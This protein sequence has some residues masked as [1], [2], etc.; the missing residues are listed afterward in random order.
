MIPHS[1][2][3]ELQI[4]NMNGPD[5]SPDTI[6]EAQDTILESADLKFD[7]TDC[8]CSPT[9]LQELRELLRKHS[10]AFVDKTELGVCPH[11][12]HKIIL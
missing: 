10:K 2:I 3:K 8:H 12:K 7:F 5:I 9:E 4:P 6:L 1:D 11:S